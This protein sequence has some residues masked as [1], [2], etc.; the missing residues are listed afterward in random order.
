MTVPGVYPD[1]VSQDHQVP[2][3]VFQVQLPHV[4]PVVFL[5][6][7]QIGVIT[8]QPVVVHLTVAVPCHWIAFTVV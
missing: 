8:V 6:T 3:P 2:P 5:S 4:P 1:G 7:L